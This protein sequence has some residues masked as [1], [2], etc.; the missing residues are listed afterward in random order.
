M[1]KKGLSIVE[2][3]IAIML[4]ALIM[5]AV[6]SIF[7]VALK[8]YRVSFSQS[9][10]Q[11]EVNLSID[12]IT[13]RVKQ[14]VEIPET[15]PEALGDTEKS[16]TVLIL[17]L[18]AIDDNENF[19]YNGDTLEKDY[20]IYYLDGSGLHKS[21]SANPLS[22]RNDSDNLILSEIS[23]L[24]FS[25]TPNSP[26]AEITKVDISVTVSRTVSKTDINITANSSAVKRNYE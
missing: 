10:L 1:R 8:N 11:R 6:S 2:L 18:P 20:Y 7:S 21:V 3:L 26:G 14:S 9:T 24:T 23:N 4:L 12:S 19:I 17:A 22:S 5:A 25:Y 15:L 16:S 13:R